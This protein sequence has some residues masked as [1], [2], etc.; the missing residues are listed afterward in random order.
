MIIK[1][2]HTESGPGAASE[3]KPVLPKVKDMCEEDQPRERAERLGCGALSVADLWALVLRTGSIGNPV[4]KLT[5]DMMAA[6]NNRLTYLERRTRAELMQIKGL[7]KTKAI[8]VEAVMELIRRYN[9]EEPAELP[10]VMSSKDLYAVIKPPI[11]HLPH[12]EIWVVIMDN[13]HRV[14]KLFQAGKGG[15]TSTL[16]DI[17]VIM[18]EVLVENATAIALC[19][20]HPSGTMRPS[21]QDDEITR[22]C[23]NACKL[24]EISMLDHII[25][26]PH[27]Y[28]SYNDEGRLTL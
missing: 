24:L 8:Q 26:S 19:H 22:R 17:K 20:N 15:W 16:F 1:E 13:K 4:T 10:S 21:R 2:S 9:S 14:V 12:E 27:A 3:P 6:S 7:G 23:L 28:Y 18:K 11:A 5:R 25:V